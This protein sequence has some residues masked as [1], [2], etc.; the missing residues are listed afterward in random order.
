MK[1][2][3]REVGVCVSGKSWRKNK[4]MIKMYCLKFPKNKKNFK[5]VNGK[6]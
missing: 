6:N 4:N 5:K 1:F 2:G 3:G